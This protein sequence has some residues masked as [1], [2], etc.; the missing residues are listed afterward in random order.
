MPRGRKRRSSRKLS[1]DL[2]EQTS[3]IRPSVSIP[4]LQYAHFVPG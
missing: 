1:Y 4:V 2:P 3:M